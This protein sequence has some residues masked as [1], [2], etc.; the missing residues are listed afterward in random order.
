MKLA[1]WLVRT[2]R[3][4]ATKRGWVFVGVVSMVP[5]KIQV[6]TAQCDKKIVNL[7]DNFIVKGYTYNKERSYNV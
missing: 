2:A 6:D 7:Y 4:L 5:D 1:I 3:L